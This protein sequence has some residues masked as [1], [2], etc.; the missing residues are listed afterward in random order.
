MIDFYKYADEALSQRAI[1]ADLGSFLLLRPSRFEILGARQRKSAVC[2][3]SDRLDLACQLWARIH[4][5]TA[6]CPEWAA[7]HDMQ[8]IRMP[9]IE[10]EALLIPTNL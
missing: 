5:Q 1:P 2:R 6:V 4:S 3:K 7:T 10:R 9:C 8:Q